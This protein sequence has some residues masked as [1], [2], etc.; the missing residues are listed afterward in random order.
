[1]ATRALK[2]PMIVVDE[3]TM[4]ALA[5]KQAALATKKAMN[6]CRQSPTASCL[7]CSKPCRNMM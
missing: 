1:M 6:A 2:K 4:K 5:K 7:T 3:K